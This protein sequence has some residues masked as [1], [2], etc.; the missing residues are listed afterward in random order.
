M[1]PPINV[2]QDCRARKPPEIRRRI[3]PMLLFR[4]R[5]DQFSFTTLTARRFRSGALTFRSMRKVSRFIRRRMYV[6]S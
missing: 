4:V 2:N 1:T 6:S 3:R 5:P